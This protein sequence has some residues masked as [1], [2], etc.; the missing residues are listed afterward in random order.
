[1]IGLCVCQRKTGKEKAVVTHI[2]THVHQSWDWF[3]EIFYYLYYSKAAN[4]NHSLSSLHPPPPLPT[5]PPP[6]PPPPIPFSVS[7]C[8]R[9]TSLS[10]AIP[11]AGVPKCWKSLIERRKTLVKKKGKK[12]ERVR[13]SFGVSLRGSDFSLFTRPFPLSLHSLFSF[14]LS[15]PCSKTE[16]RWANFSWRIPVAVP[17]LTFQGARKYWEYTACWC[18]DESEL[19]K[20]ASS[21]ENL[22]P[23]M[24]KSFHNKG[25]ALWNC[26]NLIFYCWAAMG[27]AALCL[28]VYG[29]TH[30]SGFGLMVKRTLFDL[31]FL[32]IWLGQFCVFRLSTN[33]YWRP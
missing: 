18:R 9:Y 33:Q 30:Y 23:I 1:M 17:I 27:S 15:P 3:Q 32:W 31:A 20:T 7:P 8:I 13:V 4:H 19:D 29:V 2:H 6:P 26:Y 28:C 21:R 11:C 5:T 14:P 22:V 24:P 10:P 16:K 25:Q 12:T